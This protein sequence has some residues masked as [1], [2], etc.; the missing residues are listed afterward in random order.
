MR[1]C[2]SRRAVKMRAEEASLVLT[3]AIA[4]RATRLAATT[5][6]IRSSGYEDA[7]ER[8]RWWAVIID[9]EMRGV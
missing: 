6:G 7:I 4:R 2:R 9:Y 8:V 5:S 1:V 3:Q